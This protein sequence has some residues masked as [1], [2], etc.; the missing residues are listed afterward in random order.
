[1][2]LYIYIK[3]HIYLFNSN[4]ISMKKA[5]LTVINMTIMTELATRSRFFLQFQK[6]LH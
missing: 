6:D 4:N 5:R 1:M 3:V 2:S